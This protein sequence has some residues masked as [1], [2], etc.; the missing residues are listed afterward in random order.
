MK[1]SILD[2]FPIFVWIRVGKFVDRHVFYSLANGQTCRKFHVI[3]KFSKIHNYTYLGV[4]YFN[5]ITTRH[6][7]IQIRCDRIHSYNIFIRWARWRSFLQNKEINSNQWTQTNIIL[8]HSK[9][10]LINVYLR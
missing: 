2:I 5:N 4:K 9:I 3:I 8:L 7:V 1:L 10:F 6:F